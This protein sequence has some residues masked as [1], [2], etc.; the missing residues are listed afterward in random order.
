MES[1]HSM[2]KCKVNK[3]RYLCTINESQITFK[4]QLHSNKKENVLGACHSSCTPLVTWF[5]FY[6]YIEAS[7]E[8]PHTPPP[9]H[10]FLS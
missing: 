8:R 3:K 1:Q 9:S 5:P 7:K 6:F 2:I 4:L 10:V